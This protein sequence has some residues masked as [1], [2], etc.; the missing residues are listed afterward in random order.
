MM[1]QKSFRAGCEHLSQRND[2]GLCLITVGN[3]LRGDDGVAETL[4]NRLSAKVLANVCRFDLGTHTN[5]LRDCLTGHRAAFIIDSICDDEKSPGA[6]TVINLNELL[7]YQRVR[8]KSSHGLS[9]IDELQLA[10]EQGPLPED[11]TFFG[12]VIDEAT[13]GETLSPPIVENLPSLVSQLTMLLE[14]ILESTPGN[15]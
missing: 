1:R 8:I 15:A 13:W 7:G 3:S 9:I 6:V 4:C 12:V 11:I 10:K 5:Y 14:S 2:S